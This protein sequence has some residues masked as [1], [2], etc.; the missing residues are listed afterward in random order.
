M[1]NAISEKRLAEL[2][3]GLDLPFGGAMVVGRY[4]DETLRPVF[5]KLRR[6][7]LRALIAGYRGARDVYRW[8]KRCVEEHPGNDTFLCPRAI[9]DRIEDHETAKEGESD[10]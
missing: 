8:A 5:V 7:E 9:I 4:E 3:K 1:S 6:Y 2:E 10:G